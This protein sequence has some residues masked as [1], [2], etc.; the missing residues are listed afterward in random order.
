[1]KSLKKEGEFTKAYFFKQ[2][3]DQSYPEIQN[4]TLVLCIC[5]IDDLIH[6]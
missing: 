3:I 5:C 6:H 4:E 2:F 1:M